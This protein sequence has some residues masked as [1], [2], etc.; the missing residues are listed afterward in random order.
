MW[1]DETLGFLTAGGRLH[2]TMP[3]KE[4]QE[5]HAKGS[6]SYMLLRWGANNTDIVEVVVRVST[7][8]QHT[9]TGF[10]RT[11]ALDGTVIMG[12][13]ASL[14]SVSCTGPCADIC[15]DRIVALTIGACMCE[16]ACVCL[17]VRDCVGACVCVF[18][19]FGATRTLVLAHTCTL[20]ETETSTHDSLSVCRS[21]SNS[22]VRAHTIRGSQ[23]SRLAD[24]ADAPKDSPA[25][26][27]C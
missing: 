22:H 3:L 8:Q 6:P 13:D 4:A 15:Y 20:T 12:A 14:T 7:I 25:K 19:R 16:G 9:A 26:A 17:R 1:F 18:L 24:G 5:L 21:P 23:G 10:E 27:R 2:E 11:E